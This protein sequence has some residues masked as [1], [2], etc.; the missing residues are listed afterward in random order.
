MVPSLFRAIWPCRFEVCI[1]SI[2]ICYAK[3][4]QLEAYT[5]ITMALRAVSSHQGVYLKKTYK[6][7]VLAAIYMMSGAKRPTKS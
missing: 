1:S 3:T 7:K 6:Q 5:I 2:L 4:G